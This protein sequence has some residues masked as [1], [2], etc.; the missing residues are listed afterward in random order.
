MRYV[1]TRRIF[2]IVAFA[3]FGCAQSP[4]H[5]LASLSDSALLDELRWLNRGPDTADF[6]AGGR[7]GYVDAIRMELLSRHP[8]WSQAVADAIMEGRVELGMTMPQTAA[9]IGWPREYPWWE[10][11]RHP[12]GGDDFEVWSA[13]QNM[14]QWTYGHSDDS[15][16]VWFR[17]GR[18]YRIMDQRTGRIEEAN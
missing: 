7:S 13:R 6:G 2:V 3:I 18:V 16:R 12:L 10:A 17:D 1:F 15:L 11:R 8:E 9:A 4:R 5:N 14:K